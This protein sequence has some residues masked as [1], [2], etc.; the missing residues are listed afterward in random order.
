MPE[1]DIISPKDSLAN[2]VTAMDVHQPIIVPPIT[3]EAVEKPVIKEEPKEE[4]KEEIK[5]EEN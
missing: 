4:V 5:I 3:E 1:T 2:E